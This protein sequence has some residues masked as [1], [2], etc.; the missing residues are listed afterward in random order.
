MR[1]IHDERGL[2]GRQ[3]ITLMILIVVGGLAAV[4]A[5]AVLFAKL[6]ASDLADSAASAGATAYG[7][8]KSASAAKAAALDDLRSQD[9]KARITRFTVTPGGTVTVTVRKL[10]STLIVR[11]VS[12]FRYFGVV[13]D[14]SSS[15]P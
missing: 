7:P 8:T 4:D 2:V 12:L 14:T 9:T 6:Q 15:G 5:T 13:H 1:R 3:A 10:A 11:H